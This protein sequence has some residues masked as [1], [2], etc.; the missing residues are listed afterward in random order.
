MDSIKENII[1][2]KTIDFSLAVI[3]YVELL[4]QNRKLFVMRFAYYTLRCIK[5]C[6]E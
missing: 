5:M 2:G 6:N 3:E 1:L 4:E